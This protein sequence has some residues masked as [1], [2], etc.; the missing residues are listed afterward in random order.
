MVD[1]TSI[2]RQYFITFTILHYYCFISYYSLLV[3]VS[4]SDV[5]NVTDPLSKVE[6]GLKVDGGV[7]PLKAVHVKAQL[8]DL[9]AKVNTA[10][11]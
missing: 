10:V 4:L 9:A 6:A 8:I 7:V 3:G 1:K 5:K 2:N 11:S